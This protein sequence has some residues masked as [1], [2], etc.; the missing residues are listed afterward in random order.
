MNRYER[1]IADVLEA[2]TI[3]SDTGFLWFGQHV[4]D[5]PAEVA[6]AL[7]EERR[8]GHLGHELASRLYADCY[9]WGRPRPSPAPLERRPP[10]GTTP[11]AAALAEANRGR[12]GVWPGWR[13]IGREGEDVLVERGGLTL[14]AR[15]DDLVGSVAAPGALVGVRREKGLA[16]PLPRLLYRARR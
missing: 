2:T 4:D 8:R 3:V 16:A 11:L 5:L 13:V 7:P 15:P 10:L 14:R 9:R 1:T 12:G 6:A